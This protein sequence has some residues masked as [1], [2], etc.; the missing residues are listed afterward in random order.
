MI[1]SAPEPF[2]N[3][4]TP[5]RNP[6]TE[7]KQ[8][9]FCILGDARVFN[10]RSPVIFNRVIR[11]AG[12][13]GV[14]VP[15]MVDPGKVSQA[16]ESLRVLNIA[17]A[18]ITV[19]YKEVVSPCMDTLSEGAQIIG[20]INTVARDGENLKGY[21][22]NAIGFMDALEDAG[23]DPAGKTI[24]VFGTGGAARAVVFMLN[25]MQAKTIH[26]SGRS[27]EQTRAIIDRI[28]G[29]A[30]PVETLTDAPIDIHL[31]INATS[32]SSPDESP[33]LA[34]TASRLHLKEC[35]LV[36]DLNYGRDASIWKDVAKKAHAPFLDGLTTL[37]NQ[38][39]RSFKLWTGLDVEA[40]EFLDAVKTV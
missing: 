24:L 25:W 26:I 27:P 35:E 1:L 30:R 16:V 23:F 22:T 15:F 14:Y 32:V 34:E 36:I 38:A 18:N 4:H 33:E 5:V 7:I 40:K 29:Q 12:V 17:G 10:S 8:K 13:N 39:R 28:G 9:V 20:A 21:N 3:I 19:P 6:K 2:M 37:A 31:L 11:R